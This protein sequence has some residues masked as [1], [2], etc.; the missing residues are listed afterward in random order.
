LA[1]LLFSAAGWLP[2]GPTALLFAAVE[3]F[4]ALVLYRLALPGL[5]RHLLQREKN[6]L[7][8][9]TQEVE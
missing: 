5:G 4:V 2:A 3:L 8:I 7:Q 6:I 1:G 9:V